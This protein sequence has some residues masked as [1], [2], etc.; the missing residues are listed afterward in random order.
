M[1]TLAP[2]PSAPA[3]EFPLLSNDRLT[4]EV[5]APGHAYSG[6][7]FEWAGFI[8][9]VT[10]DGKHT[11]CV[12]ES[13]NGSGTGGAGLCSE[14]GIHG[15]P[16]YD[17]A[18]PGESFIKP[19]VGVLTRT[20][21]RPYS[22]SRSYPL[23]PFRHRIESARNS[24]IFI[25]DPIDC[26]GYSMQTTKVL[27]LVANRLIVTDTLENTGAQPIELD[28]YCHNFV[29]ID[30]RSVGPDTSL[31]WTR[32]AAS[33]HQARPQ[34]VEIAAHHATWSSEPTDVFYAPVSLL[35]APSLS[36]DA[37][38]LRHE[39]TGVSMSETTS[40][41]WSRFAIFGNQRLVSPEAFIAIRVA[42]G[43][44][45]TWSREFEFSC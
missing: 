10:L 44:T 21:D 7:R 31:S 27:Q 18:L 45:K 13:I 9:Q 15:V 22:F 40:E 1:T 32:A 29:A 8:T 30:G 23:R 24:L 17:D 41:P 33:L 39:P 34:Q 12:P 28:H 19:G 4:I 2:M 37:W 36:R 3:R 38:R 42:P 6:T 35:P 16:G 11:F 20:D 25:C 43:E 14:Y 26:R 5:A